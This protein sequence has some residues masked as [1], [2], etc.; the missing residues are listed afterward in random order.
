[1]PATPTNQSSSAADSSINAAATAG[2]SVGD[3]A[4]PTQQQ[5][6]RGGRRKKMLSFEPNADF[7]VVD[8]TVTTTTPETTSGGGGGGGGGNRVRQRS[9]E[10][11]SRRQ[12]HNAEPLM[13]PI[14]PRKKVL[15]MP[16]CSA[17]SNEFFQ[18]TATIPSAVIME[19]SVAEDGT[20][21]SSSSPMQH[22][23]QANA[24][25][26]H[27]PRSPPPRR[28]RQNTAPISGRGGG[29]FQPD[30]VPQEATHPSTSRRPRKKTNSFMAGVLARRAV[31]MDL[32]PADDA[33]LGMYEFFRPQ[34]AAAAPVGLEHYGEET[35][36][37]EEEELEEKD[38]ET[39]AA[40]AGG[41]GGEGAEVTPQ[42]KV[43]VAGMKKKLFKPL[44]FAP[45][46]MMAGG[47]GGH[48]GGHGGGGHGGGH[49]GHPHGGGGAF[50]DVVA[51]TQQVLQDDS[52]K[53]ANIIV[54]T[55]DGT[56]DIMD[57]SEAIPLT[58]AK[59][60]LSGKKKGDEF[61]DNG[62]D[63]DKDSEDGSIV[64]QKH[65]DDSHIIRATRKDYFF[66]GFLVVVMSALVG[67][68][69]GWPTHLDESDSIFGPV[70]LAC[71]TPCRGDVYDQDYFRG[72]NTFHSGDVIY[73]TPHIDT[74]LTEESYLRM[75]IRGVQSNKTKWVSSDDM[76]GPASVGEDGK[77][78]TKR[79]RVS[80]NWE[81]PEEQHVIDVWSTVS[82]C[83]LLAC[84]IL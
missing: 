65:Y 58:T 74:T 82:C 43:E 80:V 60:E 21:V 63:V 34:A 48:G 28:T 49:G 67:V 26:S 59:D 77:R 10:K 30:D 15:S 61:I 3:T 56:T 31:A 2:D 45:R 40:A 23:Q 84:M 46:R 5:P 41:E 25:G 72:K 18:G 20:V 14:L 66:T 7:F 75:V 11:N 33:D 51:S 6:S 12:P 79:A 78:V 29:F 50:C 70:G 62:D 16:L 36:E 55:K 9:H 69:V 38:L 52:K 27:A 19:E 54:A 73:L 4:A 1:M 76:F 22:H 57:A 35:K 13:G 81:S 64:A 68:V 71:K 53:P 37:E 83:I 24:Q 17:A 39:G 44:I 8:S 32:L 47:G 42:D